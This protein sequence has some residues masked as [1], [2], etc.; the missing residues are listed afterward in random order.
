MTELDPR[1]PVVGQL[2]ELLRATG[3]RP[4]VLTV[5]QVAVMLALKESS[6]RYYAKQGRIPYVMLGRNMRFIEQDII[7]YLDRLRRSAV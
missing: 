2:Q 5:S 7:A 3:Q 6:V 4:H 1:Q